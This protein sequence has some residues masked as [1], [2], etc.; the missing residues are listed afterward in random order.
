MFAGP[1]NVYVHAQDA[2]GVH[3]GWQTLGPFSALNA[4]PAIR[5]GPLQPASDSTLFLQIDIEDAN[6]RSD[7][8]LARIVIN[9]AL[10]YAGGCVLELN[11]AGG[12]YRLANDGG[13]AWSPPVSS[14]GP[15]QQNSQCRVRSFS[16]YSW[17][18]ST[19]RVNL[20]IAF[21]SP[22]AG[23]KLIYGVGQ[24]A[25]G[26]SGGWQQLQPFQVVNALPVTTLSPASGRGEF[27]SFSVSVTDANG[28]GDISYLKI[29]PVR[30]ITD[31]QS[32]MI[33]VFPQ[34]RTVRLARDDGTWPPA[35]AFNLSAPLENSQCILMDFSSK[36]S[37]ENVLYYFFF[38]R[39]KGPHAGPLTTYAYAQD[40]A[41]QSAGWS[42]VGSWEAFVN[43]APIVESVT[44]SVGAGLRQ[45]FDFTAFDGNGAQDLSLLQGAVGGYGATDC[46]FQFDF[47]TQRL[48]L[49]QSNGVFS[50]GL[51]LG[52]PG[53]LENSACRIEMPTSQLILAQNRATVRLDIAFK[54]EYAGFRP[55]YATVYDKYGVSNT[56]NY[57][58]FGRWVVGSNNSPSVVSV[59]PSGGSGKSANFILSVADP[60][61]AGDIALVYFMVHSGIVG[62]NSCFLAFRPADSSVRLLNDAGT[63]WIQPL[64]AAGMENSQ[65]RVTYGGWL[66]SASTGYLYV[67]ITF[68][69]TFFGMRKSFAFVQDTNGANSDWMQAGLWTVAVP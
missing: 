53:F 38:V 4:A 66:T 25:R 62:Q 39:F 8:Q 11:P 37:E 17:S 35:V 15:H 68:K 56:G 49:V 46:A 31:I 44:P 55:I 58:I 65:C 7:V 32:C 40:S 48:S 67:S 3:S 18:W 59:S 47:T 20:S 24:D 21:S 14:A 36:G 34:A 16:Q 6:G 12:T 42:A 57:T 19:N 69:D 54:Q 64:S 29:G 43:T 1:K 41:G 30:A 10:A 13:W 23:P 2:V 5:I 52:G 61:G 27:A 22:F 28:A 50:S 51:A 45:V 60:N 33:E 26:A 63:D 9:S